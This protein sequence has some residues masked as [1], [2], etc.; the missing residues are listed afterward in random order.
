MFTR[1]LALVLAL[2]IASPSFAVYDNIRFDRPV[3]YTAG[4]ALRT[5]TAAGTGP[6]FSMCGSASKTIYVHRFRLSGTVATAAAF[7]DLV[8]KK[9][10]TATSAGTPAAMTRV[11]LDS[12]YPAAT[13]TVNYYTALGTAGALV[14][15]VATANYVLPTAT[16]NI[17]VPPVVIDLSDETIGP[18]VLRG[19]AQ[20]LEANFGTTTTNAPSLLIDVQWV[21]E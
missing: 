19:T 4:L 14:G 18:V 15:V 16:S 17:Q 7:A 6:F 12:I 1:I 8:L 13:A 9:T 5:A 2:F 20:C 3:T 10:S 11:P 21:E